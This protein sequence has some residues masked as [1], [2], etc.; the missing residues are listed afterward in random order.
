M[1]AKSA[2]IPATRAQRLA[3]HTQGLIARYVT[4]AETSSHV[5]F[6]NVPTEAPKPLRDR[7]CGRP[8]PRLRHE[9]AEPDAFQAPRAVTARAASRQPRTLCWMSSSVAIRREAS[10][11][12]R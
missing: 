3:D 4:G 2:A 7:V 10:L 12:R 11:I 1:D 5:D 6:V 9:N 8:K